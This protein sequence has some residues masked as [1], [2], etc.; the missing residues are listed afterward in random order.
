MPATFIGTNS[1]QSPDVVTRA[2]LGTELRSSRVIRSIA[3][4]LLSSS[5]TLSAPV[6]YISEPTIID[7]VSMVVTQITL[8]VYV[9]INA[10]ISLDG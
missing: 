1:R 2:L 6:T 8:Y 9:S 10:N 4:R 3:K 5:F 7:I